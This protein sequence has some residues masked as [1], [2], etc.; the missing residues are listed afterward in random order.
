M[1]SDAGVSLEIV[2]VIQAVIILLFTAE[3][4]V[5][6]FRARRKRSA[7]PAQPM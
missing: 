5:N 4:L 7:V 6:L 1:Q 2:R 3:G